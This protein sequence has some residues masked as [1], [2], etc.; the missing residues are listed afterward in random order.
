MLSK[1]VYHGLSVSY[2]SPNQCM[3]VFIQSFLWGPGNHWQIITVTSKGKAKGWDLALPCKV[4]ETRLGCSD[5]YSL[6][7][8]RQ[9]EQMIK[10]C[11]NLTFIAEGCSE[12]VS[13]HRSYKMFFKQK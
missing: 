7:R 4:A 12:G 6:P 9:G 3:N 8:W 1:L 13:D 11:V 10:Q 2:N 5:A